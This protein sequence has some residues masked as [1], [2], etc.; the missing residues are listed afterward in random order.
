ML[1]EQL[2]LEKLRNVVSYLCRETEMLGV[3][4]DQLTREPN[5][6]AQGLT[7]GTH[8]I[9]SCLKQIEELINVRAHMRIKLAVLQG[10][11]LR[12]ASVRADNFMASIMDETQ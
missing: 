1:S 9:E 10:T 2:T 3:E 11:L 4:I 12:Y 7:Y 6:G 5:H 8:D